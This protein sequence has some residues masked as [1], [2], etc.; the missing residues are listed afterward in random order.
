VALSVFLRLLIGPAVGVALVYAMGLRG[1]LAEMLVIS[2]STPTAVNCMLLCLE[3][4]NH[5]DFAAKAVLYS[6]VLSPV[7]VTL[8]IFLAQSGLLPA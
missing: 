8:A 3:F 7:T 4:D 6:T 5:P 1:H 2:T